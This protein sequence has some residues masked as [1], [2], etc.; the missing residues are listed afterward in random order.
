MV[1]ES[2]RHSG[3]RTW[4]CAVVR[5]RKLAAPR[6]LVNIMVAISQLCR[7]L[8]EM[9][10]LKSGKLELRASEDSERLGRISGFGTLYVPQKESCSSF[11]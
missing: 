6:R 9:T 2:A 3:Y 1:R 7:D 8:L 5:P 10:V 11:T 4:K